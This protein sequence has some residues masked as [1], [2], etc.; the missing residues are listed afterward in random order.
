MNK[1]HLIFIQSLVDEREEFEEIVYSN[2]YFKMLYY[3]AISLG[4]F[5]IL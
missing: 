1:K 5:F 2:V 4:T 3:F